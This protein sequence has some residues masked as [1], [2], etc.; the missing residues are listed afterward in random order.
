MFKKKEKPVLDNTGA[1]QPSQEYLK[2]LYYTLQKLAHYN[3]IDTYPFTLKMSSS[4]HLEDVYIS[5]KDCL[6]LML[7]DKNS[8]YLGAKIILN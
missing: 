7:E 3:D 1:E 6:V 5:Y 8:Y 4:R 2:S